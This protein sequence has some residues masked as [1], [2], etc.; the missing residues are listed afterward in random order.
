MK[1]QLVSG[2]TSEIQ[3]GMSSDRIGGRADPLVHL[4]R[5]SPYAMAATAQPKTLCGRRVAFGRHLVPADA[6]ICWTCAWRARRQQLV[7][8]MRDIVSIVRG[9]G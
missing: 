7:P 9:D 6:G 1:Y 8:V 5:A 4:W 3:R 2:P